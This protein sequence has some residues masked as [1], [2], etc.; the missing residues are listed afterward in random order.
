MNCSRLG[1]TNEATCG[2]EI[3]VPVVG[4]HIPEPDPIRCLTGIT[5]CQ[6]CL[7]GVQVAQFLGDDL[8]KIVLTIASGRA[9]PDFDRAFIRGVSLQSPEWVRFMEGSK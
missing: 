4:C 7:R 1:C 3:L 8:R 2:A 5:L 6:E 9:K